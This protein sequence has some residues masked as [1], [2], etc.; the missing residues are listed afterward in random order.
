VGKWIYYLLSVDLADLEV[1]DKEK[2]KELSVLIVARQTLL[3]VVF[4]FLY[5]LVRRCPYPYQLIVGSSCANTEPDAQ[6]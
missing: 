3:N 2:V 1:Q 5:L 6:V 4:L